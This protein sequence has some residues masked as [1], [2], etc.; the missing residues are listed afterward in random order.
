[1]KAIGCIHTGW[2]WLG[3]LW[4]RHQRNTVSCLTGRKNSLIIRDVHTLCEYCVTKRPEL[5]RDVLRFGLAKHRPCFQAG[6]R[7]SPM[8]TPRVNIVLSLCDYCII[9]T[10]I[11]PS[12]H[13]QLLLAFV[14]TRA[15]GISGGCV[16]EFLHCGSESKASMPLLHKA[17]P[18]A[19][20]WE[21][22][23][24]L[25]NQCSL[26]PSAFCRSVSFRQIGIGPSRVL[27]RNRE[28]KQ[29]ENPYCEHV[30]PPAEGC[31][32]LPKKRPVFLH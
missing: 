27:R 10:Q 21:L 26:C 4:I 16:R 23:Q 6:E 29:E 11:Q 24:F 17:Y 28:G 20:R 5:N 18:I 8:F 7:N 30:C 1:M 22:S 25:R 31:S 2:N 14:H 13:P 12:F 15:A 3:R 9:K 32:V 19:P